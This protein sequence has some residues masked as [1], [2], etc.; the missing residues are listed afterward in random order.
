MGQLAFPTP[1]RDRARGEAGPALAL[2]LAAVALQGLH[3]AEHVAQVIQLFFLRLPVPEGHGILG[4]AFDTEWL[5]FGYN[6]ALFGLLVGVAL[7]W[8][9]QLGARPATTLLIGAVALQ[10]YHLGEHLLKVAQHVATGCEP[11]ASLVGALV[12]LPWLHFFINLGVLALMTAALA[13]IAAPDEGEAEAQEV[14]SP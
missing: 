1:R 14:I 10:G 9:R 12:S 6:A 11:C 13:G 3:F 2:L 4:A 7:A 8:P 5:H